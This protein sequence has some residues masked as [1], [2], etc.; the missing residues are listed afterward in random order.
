MPG[1]SSKCIACRH[2]TAVVLRVTELPGLSDVGGPN[3]EME[4]NPKR[5][6]QR[7]VFGE[8]VPQK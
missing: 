5:Q 8:A 4:A 7:V 3:T 6:Y 1:V 2:C